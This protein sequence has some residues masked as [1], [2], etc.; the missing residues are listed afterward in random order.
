M[1][2]HTIKTPTAELMIVELPKDSTFRELFGVIVADENN[3]PNYHLI[4]YKFSDYTLL[5]KPDEISE[6]DAMKLVELGDANPSGDRFVLGYRSYF[7]G[8]EDDVPQFTCKTATESLLSAIESVIFWNVNPYPYPSPYD[9]RSKTGRF[10]H[11][12]ELEKAEKNYNEAQ[13]KT[14]DHSRSIILVKQ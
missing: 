3:S 14:F 13:E 10:E 7:E 8:Y 2:T 9:P 4:E 5:G 6:D 12:E 1:K 11:G